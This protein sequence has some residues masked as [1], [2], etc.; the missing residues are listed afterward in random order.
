MTFVDRTVTPI[1][2]DH[3]QRRGAL[4]GD[5]LQH[6]QRLFFARRPRRA[7]RFDDATLLESDLGQRIAQQL[8]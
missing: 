2:T 6:L 3:R 1:A 7:R 5:T 4:G 8:V